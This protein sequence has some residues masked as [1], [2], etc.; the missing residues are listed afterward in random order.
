M[1]ETSSFRDEDKVDRRIT[2]LE[3]NTNLNQL[4]ANIS[5]KKKIKN[6]NP[7]SAQKSKILIT[8]AFQ[9]IPNK[10]FTRNGNLELTNHV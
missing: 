9:N 2:F 1:F 4:N 5:R 8:A 6:A 10:R 3:I 7:F